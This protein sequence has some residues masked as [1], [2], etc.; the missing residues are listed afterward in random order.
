MIQPKKY[1]ESRAFLHWYPREIEDSNQMENGLQGQN[2]SHISYILRQLSE[3]ELSHLKCVFFK[4]NSVPWDIANILLMLK[5]LIQRFA[6]YTV[7]VVQNAVLQND[8]KGF[9][10]FL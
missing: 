6:K 7:P 10:S 8:I 9:P 4:H 5:S 2:L 3:R 1:Q